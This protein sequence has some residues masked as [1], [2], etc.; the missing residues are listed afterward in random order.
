MAAPEASAAA[1]PAPSGDRRDRLDLLLVS[2]LLLFLELAMI[3]WIPGNVRVVGYYSNLVLVS[4]FFGF[5]LGCILR[6]RRDVFP[7]LPPLLLVVLLLCRHLR[8]A[9][10]ANP[11]WSVEYIFGGG[12]RYGWLV[13]V[14]AIFV[15]NALPFVAIGQKTAACLDR[16]RP[17]PGYTVNVAGSLAGTLAFAAVS[18]LELAPGWWFGIAALTTL[19]LLGGGRVRRGAGALVLA[20]AVALVVADARGSIWSAYY[21]I[22]VEALGSFAPGG[23]RIVV[24][25]D[26]HQ[27]VLDLSRR[28]VGFR[29]ALLDWQLTYDCPYLGRPSR[30]RAV[31][32]LGAGAGNDVAA[33]LRAGATR[34]DA[35]ELDPTIYR[36]GRSLHPEHPYADPR[37][38]AYV[39]DARN[40]LRTSRDSY[41][42]I[43]LGWLDS[44]RLFSSLSNVR[45]DNF[46]YTV[47]SM[48]RLRDRLADDGSLWLSF[49][50]G[51]GWVGDKIFA[52]LREAF[53]HDPE[54]YALREGAYGR[55]G[56]IFAID[57]SAATIPAGLPAD[58]V[59]RT[60][61][62]RARAGHALPPT[63]DWPYLYYRDHHLSTEYVLL[64]LLVMLSAGV[65][66]APV[67]AKRRFDAPEALH[68]L[69][70]GAGFLLLEVRNITRL[71]IVFGSTWLTASLVISAVL[72]MIL[73][74]NFA[75][76]R[77]VTRGRERAAWALLL[78]S[79]VVSLLWREDL[80]PIASPLLLGL[81]STVVISLT[82]LFAG[83]VFAQSF[84]RVAV[85]SVALGFNV[86]GAV[87]GGMTEYASIVVG[88]DGLS[89]IA[90][91]IYLVAML[92]DPGVRSRRTAPGRKPSVP[93]R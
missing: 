71:A 11:G 34:V 59:D 84:S 16:F 48:A 21:K 85:P 31:L 81:L 65:M 62:F 7:L 25:H 1:V 15:V 28:T 83:I 3:R 58:F 56:L 32:V 49:Y 45:Q 41:D 18:F 37:V 36:L 44:H 33:A 50:A 35:V 10:V 87:V 5:G 77:G 9:G 78:A 80:V 20:A 88:V 22:D 55:D 26:Y 43:V 23:H 64:T 92:L 63:D 6:R 89:W 75:V 90:L 17:I 74:A 24:N 14:V 29:P 67:V 68:F 76:S 4:A 47:E 19:P 2:F 66:V 93:G 8:A 40:F 73:A 42:L 30:P 61:D 51:K 52:M 82:F 46:V 57:R 70:L 91:A 60:S 72:I 38:R 12:G 86:L 53:G 69:L 13:A 79:I 54:V 27:L 39:D